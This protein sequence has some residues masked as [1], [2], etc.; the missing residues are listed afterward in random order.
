MITKIRQNPRKTSL[1]G[2]LFW[3]LSRPQASP[4]PKPHLSH[5][6]ATPRPPLGHSLSTPLAIHQNPHTNASKSI[7]I[8]QNAGEI[9]ARR[10]RW[11]KYR[12]PHLEWSV[13]DTP[14]PIFLTAVAPEGGPPAAPASSAPR[15][16]V[17]CRPWRKGTGAWGSSGPLPLAA[18]HTPCLAP[19]CGSSHGAHASA[20]SGM[21]VPFRTRRATPRRPHA[22][23]RMARSTPRRPPGPRRV[24]RLPSRGAGVPGHVERTAP[25][26]RASSSG[27]EWQLSDPRFPRLQGKCPLVH[28]FEMVPNG[29]NGC[30][31]AILGMCSGRVL[32]CFS[33]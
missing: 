32:G 21:P 14:S 28:F 6:S 24:A 25:R 3:I 2:A 27:V 23:R 9:H 31:R 10:V 1:D 29:R 13:L 17:P 33:R 20:R 26:S 22:V 4:R 5:P 8:R 30:E 12:V 19:G 16:S 7:K 15:V 18:W 11:S